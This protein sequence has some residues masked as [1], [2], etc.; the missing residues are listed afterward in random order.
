M[1]LNSDNNDL[2][3]INN[4]LYEFSQIVQN[5]SKFS[6]KEIEP[7]TQKNIHENIFEEEL[8]IVIDELVNIYLKELKEGK[9]RKVRRQNTLDYIKN[10]YK[11][12]LQEIINWLLNNQNDSNSIYLL[13]YFNYYGIGV[14][15]DMKK[16]FKLFQLAA[17]LENNAAQLA[18]LELANMY[19]DGVGVD[20]NYDKAFELSKNLAKKGISYGI[21]LLGYCYIN[22]IGTDINVQKGVELYQK[23]AD[24]GSCI[25]QYNLAYKYKDGVG[26]ELNFIK[27]FELFKKSAEKEY[28]NGIIMLAHCYDNGIGTCIDKQKA[29]ESFQKA[30]NLENHYAQC[31]LAIMYENGDGVDKNVK[32]AIYWYKKSAK[33]GN[34]TALIKLEQ[35]KEK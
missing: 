16:A 30:A 26:V 10:N 27:A 31:C 23:A 28:T 18:Q 22:G 24:L 20:K 9:E 5:F 12:N 14:D 25:A 19:I 4:S 2:S 3:N 11:I 6:I 1:Q 13:G 34:I 32:K 8:S 21:N 17:N 33:Q 35:L 7:T 29:F 15:I